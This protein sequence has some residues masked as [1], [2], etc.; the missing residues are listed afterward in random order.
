MSVLTV[1]NLRY[2]DFGPFDF[3][4]EPGELVCVSGQSGSGKTLLL[5]ALADLQPHQGDISLDKRSQGSVPPS[6][7]R[8]WV[9][10]LPANILWWHDTV[11][12]HFPPQEGMDLSRLL[13]TLGFDEQVLQ[14]QPSRLSSGEAQRLG[15]ARLL[16]RTPKVLLLDEP[17][18]NLDASNVGIIEQVIEEYIVRHG[19]PAM[20]VSH[21]Q[22]QI[23]RI[24][25]RVFKLQGQELLVT[26]QAQ[27]GHV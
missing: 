13:S 18:A 10:L 19:A 22:E 26:D 4:L 17:T 11:A 16:A 5:R 23:Q 20:W 15:L 27:R 1:S 3:V 12:D 8:S 2:L 25:G 14:W 9:S 7:W 24:A 6:L 21:S